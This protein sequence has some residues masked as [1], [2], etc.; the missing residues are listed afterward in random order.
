MDE[1]INNRLEK[2]RK[3]REKDAWDD[4]MK[5]FYKFGDQGVTNITN[6]SISC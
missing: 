2:W 1:L 3:Q 5:Y 6:T 4:F